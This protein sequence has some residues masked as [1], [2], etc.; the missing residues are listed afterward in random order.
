MIATT[1]LGL[2]GPRLAHITAQPNLPLIKR[3]GL[4]SAASLAADVGPA[5]TLLRKD[6]RVVG[7]A[8]LNHQLPLAS[9]YRTAERL[10]EGHTP[11]SW[12]AQLDRRVFFATEAFAAKFRASFNDVQPVTL[13]LDTQ[14]LLSQMVDQMW[15]CPLNSGSF[16]QG[17]GKKPRGDWI[18]V[19]ASSDV[20]T[21]RNNRLN[22]GVVKSPD[23]K[24]KEVSI[25]APVPA[26]L[27]SEALI[28][29]DE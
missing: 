19:S 9:H 24:V 20:E 22:R 25:T 3:E 16:R 12:A 18:Y 23:T 11:E 1:I 8:I 26:A 2:L 17:G 28:S 7:H 10:L 13:W 4:K 5:S 6:R 21:Y 14:V 27:L 15:L 29:I